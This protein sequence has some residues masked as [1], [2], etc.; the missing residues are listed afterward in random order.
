M[1]FSSPAYILAEITGTHPITKPL[2]K[3]IGMFFLSRSIRLTSTAENVHTLVQT[4]DGG[5]GETD[6]SN[7]HKDKGKDIIGPVSIAVATEKNKT[8]LVVVFN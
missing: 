5:W 7:I 1:P 3:M 4:T 2:D 6:L 8:R